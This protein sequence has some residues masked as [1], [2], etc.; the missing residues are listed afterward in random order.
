MR[1]RVRSWAKGL[2]LPGLLCLLVT[3]LAVAATP[4]VEKVEVS[5]PAAPHQPRVTAEF[6]QLVHRELRRVEVPPGRGERLILSAAL[7]QL[8]CLPE[9][10]TI[11]T[12]ASVSLT[13]REQRDGAIKAL[14]NGSASSIDAEEAR[15]AARHRAME[16]AVRSALQRL[17]EALE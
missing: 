14:I 3:G 15:D 9:Q 4:P 16:A 13:L 8:D 10:D 17:P 12:R 1:T 6:S 2:A 7:T 11:K 5:T